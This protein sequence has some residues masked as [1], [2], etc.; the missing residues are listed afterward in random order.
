MT[1]HT[2]TGLMKVGHGGPPSAH[3]LE[4]RVGPRDGALNDRVMYTV[5]GDVQDSKPSLGEVIEG[6]IMEQGPDRGFVVHGG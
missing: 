3:S 2:V 1:T 5:P 6:T 4:N